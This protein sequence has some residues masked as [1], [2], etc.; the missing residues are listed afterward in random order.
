[1]ARRAA[2]EQRTVQTGCDGG[3]DIDAL[4]QV[5]IRRGA[6]DLVVAGELGDAGG[7]EEPAQHQH[8]VPPRSQR[9]PSAACPATPS[10]AVE[11]ARHERHGGLPIGSVAV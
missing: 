6:A 5:A 2:G 7:V 11:Q 10:F 8:R 4:V 9:T 3:E 1:M